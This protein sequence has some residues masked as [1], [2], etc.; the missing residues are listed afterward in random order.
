MDHVDQAFRALAL[1]NILLLLILYVVISAARKRQ[2]RV[3][4]KIDLIG[5]RAGLEEEFAALDSGTGRKSAFA[6]LHDFHDSTP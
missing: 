5:E 3:E 2:E 4:R 1:L 6:P